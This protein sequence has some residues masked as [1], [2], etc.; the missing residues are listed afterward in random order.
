MINGMFSMVMKNRDDDLSIAFTG[1]GQIH[2]G[3]HKIGVCSQNRAELIDD[4]DIT[5]GSA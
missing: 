1:D 5:S 4:A 2:G 3:Y